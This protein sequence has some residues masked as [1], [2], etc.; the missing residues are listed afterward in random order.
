MMEDVAII[1]MACRFPGSATS[2]EALWEM[3]RKG[4]SAWSEFP[5]DRLNIIGY[6]HPSGDRQGSVSP[7]NHITKDTDF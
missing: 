6:Y 3:L 2:P 5:E 4:E 1:G 7:S